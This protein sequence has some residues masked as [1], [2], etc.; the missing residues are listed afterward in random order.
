M[1]K[2]EQNDT[3]VILEQE[4]EGRKKNGIY[5]LCVLFL[6]IGIAIL[7]TIIN[8]KMKE[9][10]VD[11]S[12]D[13]DVEEAVSMTV[14][15]EISRQEL[16]EKLKS[17]MVR[18][19]AE[20]EDSTGEEVVLQGSGVVIAITEDYIDIATASHVVEQTA[21]PLIFF[22]DGSL[23]YGSVLAYGR[24]SDVAFVRVDAEAFSEGM[25]NELEPANYADTDDYN[26]LQPE[27]AVLLIGSVSKVAGNV[28][29][30]TLKEKEQFV[31]L[32]QNHMLICEATV[33][34][35]MSG[36]GTFSCEGKLIGIIVGTNG[37]DA[38]S[39]ASTDMMAEYRSISH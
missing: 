4:P 17:T 27:D 2:T 8:K 20:A 38:V 6:L 11:I 24:E 33:L 29:T 31:E 13:Q 32:F 14:Y 1:K 23:A 35:G 34:N 28:E 25:S 39:V 5:M 3:K 26:S 16:L 37:S 30:G 7:S 10:E 19:E 12:A 36:G 9:K 21:T 18:I 22:Y 15:G